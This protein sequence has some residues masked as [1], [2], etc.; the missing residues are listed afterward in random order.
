MKN[1]HTFGKQMAS[2]LGGKFGLRALPKHEDSHGFR[3]LVPILLSQVRL[4]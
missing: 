1:Y 3:M 2:G 4:P